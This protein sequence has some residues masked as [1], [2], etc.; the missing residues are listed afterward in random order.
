[1]ETS[2]SYY[3]CEELG[4][5]GLAAFGTDVLISRKASIH[6]A[7]RVYIGNH[8]R[9]DDFVVITCGPDAEVRIGNH[10]HIA[11]HA[12]LFGCGGIIL[13]DFVCASGRTSIYSTTDDYSGEVLTNPTVPEEFTRVTRKPVILRRHVVVG[14]GSVVL[15]GVTIGEG[16]ATGA[17][18]LI[19]R[20]LEPWGIYTGVP[21]CLSRPRSRHLLTLE[22]KLQDQEG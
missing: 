3:S 4:D 9:I 10:V 1:M 13:E 12:A 11:A 20:D 16:C 15:P 22:S 2:T 7:D 19:N 8:V 6:A 18:T 5:L 14:A 21:A 17:M